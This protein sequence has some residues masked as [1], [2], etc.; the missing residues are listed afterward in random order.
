MDPALASLGLRERKR[1]ET[2][3]AIQAAARRLVGE[4]GLERVTVEEI[5]AAANVSTRTFFNYFHSKHGAVVDPPPRYREMMAATLAA[6]PASEPPLRAFRGAVLQAFLPFAEDQ[7]Q[8]SELM[9]NNPEL[10]SR[11]RAGLATYEEVIIEWVA[12]RTGLDPAVSA[13]PRLLA[14]TVNAAVHLIV[15]RWRPETGV[16]GLLAL[17]REV[18]DLLEVGLRPPVP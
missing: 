17:H 15:D 13:Y 14:A 1:L 9:R 6:Q 12:G 5:A 7:Q 8:L 11:Y 18:F 16:D 3:Y 2:F 10:D 4:R